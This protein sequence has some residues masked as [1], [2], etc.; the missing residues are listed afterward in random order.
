MVES[1]GGINQVLSSVDT[2]LDSADARHSAPFCL[3][4]DLF[5]GVEDCSCANV[6]KHAVESAMWP[7]DEVY[8][9]LILEELPVCIWTIFLLWDSSAVSN[10]PSR[11]VPHFTLQRLHYWITGFRT[12]VAI[13]NMEYC[14]IIICA[15]NA[16][17]CNY[18]KTMVFAFLRQ[19]CCCG[20]L[21]YDLS[22]FHLNQFLHMTTVGVYTA[23]WDVLVGKILEGHF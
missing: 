2:P 13:A 16:S 3:E 4:P 5:S 18:F 11:A 19:K 22:M 6:T 12:H 17:I 10:L 7:H 9:T 23:G 21:N 8:L 1:R 14:L 15:L 20:P